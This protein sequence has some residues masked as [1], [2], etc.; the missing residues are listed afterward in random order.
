MLGLRDLWRHVAST[1]GN[2]FRVTTGDQTHK[3]RYDYLAIEA[4][5]GI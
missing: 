3:L 2:Q 5:L 4:E 1:E